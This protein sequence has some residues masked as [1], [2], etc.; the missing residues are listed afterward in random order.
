MAEERAKGHLA[1]H[2]RQI[3]K[4]QCKIYTYFFSIF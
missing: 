1:R 3:S 2:T 4:N